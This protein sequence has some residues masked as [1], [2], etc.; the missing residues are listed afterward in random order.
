M[1]SAG[2]SIVSAGMLGPLWDVIARDGDVQ[3]AYPEEAL[4][5]EHYSNGA[6]KPGGVIDAS[7]VDSVKELIDPVLHM[8]IAQQGRVLDVKEPETDIMRLG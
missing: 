8:E 5:I 7:N 2:R 4:S 6:V 1:A 3:K